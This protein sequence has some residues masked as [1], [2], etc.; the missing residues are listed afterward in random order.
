MHRGPISQ[1]GC[2]AVV[3]GTTLNEMSPVFERFVSISA[4]NLDIQGFGG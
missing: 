2:Y 3:I 4:S 1:S